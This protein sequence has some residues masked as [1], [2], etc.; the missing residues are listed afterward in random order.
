MTSSPKP[1]CAIRASFHAAGF[2]ALVGALILPYA[3]LRLVSS[4]QHPRIARLFF[5]GCLRLTGLRVAV[6]GAS[7]PGVDMVVANHVSYLDIPALGALLSH[8]VFVAKGEV[9]QWP[10]FG[11]LARLAGTEFIA[12][13][14]SQAAQHCQALASRLND[15]TTLIAFPEGTSSDGWDVLPF[16]STLFA[17]LDISQRGGM[18]QPVSI[19]YDHAGCAW[20]GDMT[21]AGHLWRRFG[22]LDAVVNVT[23]HD[24]VYRADFP[25]RKQLAKYCEAVVRDGVT[26]G[27]FLPDP[28]LAAAAE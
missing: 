13:N 7:A 5:K 11:F 12:R 15:G 17:A 25:D 21:L 9:A 4:S 23:F 19:A 28:A 20:Y 14:A 22:A 27:R 26:A 8:G 6:T 18:V 24:P 2:V 10:L 3:L 16:K 1:F